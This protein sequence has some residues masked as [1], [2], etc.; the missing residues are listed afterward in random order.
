LCRE[1]GVTRQ[2]LYRH[3]GPDGALRPD[4]RKL[5]DGRHESRGRGTAGVVSEVPPLGRSGVTGARV[6]PSPR[7]ERGG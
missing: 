1:L 4:G 7:G 6:E 5:L 3:V 2:T